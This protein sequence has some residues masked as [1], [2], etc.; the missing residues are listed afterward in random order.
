MTKRCLRF[1]PVYFFLMLAFLSS[2]IAQPTTKETPRF[3]GHEY[4]L[5]LE[6]VDT[7]N[8]VMMLEN[9]IQ[10]KEGVRFFMA[11]RFP[12]RYFRLRTDRVLTQN[13]FQRWVGREYPV[14][15]FGEGDAARE[16]AAVIY[17]HTKKAQHAH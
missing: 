3:S 14:L 12:V 15:T 5:Y 6:N 16:R 17:N 2:A 13:E 1:F 8:E 4:F 7:R 10:K 9:R 11:D